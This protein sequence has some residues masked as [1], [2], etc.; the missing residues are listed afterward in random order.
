M[1]FIDTYKMHVH[2]LHC[3][4]TVVATVVAVV[5]AVVAA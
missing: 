3:T 2:A 4:I 5:A 1:I